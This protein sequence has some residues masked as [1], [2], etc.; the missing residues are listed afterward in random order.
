MGW[1][2]KFVGFALA[3]LL[4][5]PALAAT[6]E[7]SRTPEEN[8][9]AL[10]EQET[11]VA[12]IG[13]R[14]AIA[15]ADAGWCADGHSLGWAL[16]EVGQYPKALRFAV[17]R[18]W[19]VP[20]G[21]NLFVAAVVPG[22]AAAEAGITAGSG[23]YSINGRTP[24][25]NPF[26]MPSAHG[27]EQ[28]ERLIDRLLAEGP[29]TLTIAG[30]DGVRREVTLRPRRA[31]KTRFLVA[32]EDEEQAYA[33]G[34][35]VLVTAGMARFTNGKDEELAAV[36]A[37]E[38][39]HNILRHVS[40]TEES[41]TPENY[42]RYLRRYLNISRSMEEEADRLSVWLLARAG[43]EARSPVHFWEH[44][45]PQHDAAGFYGRTHDRWQDRVAAIENELAAMAA[46]KGR[47][48]NA[49]PALLDRRDMVPVPGARPDIS[50]PTTPQPAG[51]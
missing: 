44:F 3:M 9:A 7:P 11:R 49:R 26:E 6:A 4:A 12:I 23:I 48:A 35:N 22:G 40:R 5:V 42:T 14:L 13:D 27:R 34:Q 43:Y 10:R 45:G 37:H 46:A 28:S 33:D 18:G 8:L 24:M 15:A 17:R 41:G 29:L 19:G 50:H 31:C 21:A 38:L 36:I 20:A 30:A 39:S 47:D 32:A 25:R 16:G 1:A 2:K 51:N